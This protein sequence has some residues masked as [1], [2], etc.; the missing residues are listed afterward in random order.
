[1]SDDFAARTANALAA[2]PVAAAKVGEFVERD[3]FRAVVNLGE[4]TVSLPFV[5]MYLPPA[6]HPVQLELRAGQM[7]VTGPARPLPGIGVISAT[8][9]PRATVTAWGVDYLLPYR[10]SY[11][12]VLGHNVEIQWTSDDGVI[13]GQ[14]T[15]TSNTVAPP[16]IPGGGVQPFHPDPFTAVDSASWGATYGWNT[17]DVWASDSYIGAWFYGSKI[18]DTIP[19]G[20][21]IKSAAIFLSPRQVSGAAPNLRYHTSA[22]RPGGAVTFAGTTFVLPSRT[23]WVSIPLAFIDYLKANNGG[24]GF[25]HGGYNIFRGTQA[26]GQSGALDISWEA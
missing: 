9:T 19:D 7:V 5:G 16:V 22:T 24:I 10:S 2:V 25:D 26:D 6:G 13:Q 23:G 11:T 14:V 3:G 21:V 12:P 18:K 15:A 8:G 1:M 17:R 4:S 20:A